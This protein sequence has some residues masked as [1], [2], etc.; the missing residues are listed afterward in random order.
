MGYGPNIGT[1]RGKRGSARFLASHMVTFRPI[2]ARNPR[3][4]HFRQKSGHYAN[5]LAESSRRYIHMLV[6][7]RS[8]VVHP[9]RNAGHIR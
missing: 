2:H 9:L 4:T 7:L 8:P 1:S 3:L 6:L 5:N